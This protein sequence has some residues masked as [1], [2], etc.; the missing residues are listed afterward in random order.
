M[1]MYCIV[2]RK[3]IIFMIFFV[4][5]RFSVNWY[6]GKKKKEDDFFFEL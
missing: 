6:I 3:K 2:L 1:C 5:L 4:V